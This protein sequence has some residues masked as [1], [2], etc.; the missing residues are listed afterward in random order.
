M[1]YIILLIN[2][3]S[4]NPESFTEKTSRMYSIYIV[5][6][7]G[8]V[9]THLKNT[10]NC[11]N[12]TISAVKRDIEIIILLSKVIDFEQLDGYIATT[13]KEITKTGLIIYDK[14]RE[15]QKKIQNLQ[16]N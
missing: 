15:I 5:Q 7:W 2:E 14:A 4:N 9:E 10:K 6:Y 8:L 16:K 13:E 11:L 12:G 3:L 1:K